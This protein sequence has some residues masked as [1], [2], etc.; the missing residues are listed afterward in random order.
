[1]LAFAYHSQRTLCRAFFFFFLRVLS[2]QYGRGAA[3]FQLAA[4]VFGRDFLLFWFT[5]ALARSR[6]GERSFLYQGSDLIASIHVARSV[7]SGHL[8]QRVSKGERIVY[9]V[10]SEA[11]CA[12]YWPLHCFGDTVGAGHSLSIM[13]FN[14]KQFTTV[15]VN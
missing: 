3:R 9:G 6:C 7:L 13:L 15:A 11:C 4:V 8:H 14:E 1:M 10:F 2:Q 5:S 12:V